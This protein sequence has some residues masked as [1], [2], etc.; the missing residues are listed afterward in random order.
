MV[1]N[2]TNPPT[3]KDRGGL[4]EDRFD[5]VSLPLP[6][7]SMSRRHAIGMISG[8][9]AGVVASNSFGV[10]RASAQP[11]Q[12]PQQIYVIR[13]G[14]KPPGDVKNA[15]DV[16][17]GPPFGVDVDG[18]L[19][20]YSLSPRGWQRS[21]ALT[22]L[23]S[24]AIAPKMGLRTPTAL[25]AS[26]YGDEAVTKIH[27]PYETILGVSRRLDLPIQSPSLLGKEPAFAEA[28]LAG[29]AEVVLIAYE[30]DH[31]PA[32]VQG[33]PTVD[34]TGIPA[35]WPGDRFDVIWTFTLNPVGGNYVFSQVPQQLLGGDADTVI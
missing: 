30:H 34:G 14:E 24:P 13:H 27:R 23:F 31:I 9:F 17:A 5:Q 16:S 8:V 3:R 33:F 20:Q 29:G 26:G 22:A 11:G 28:V 21:G 18:N 32:L 4:T 25:Y 10:Q 2:C 19:N 15:S 7:A 35:K 1:F 6:T 12:R